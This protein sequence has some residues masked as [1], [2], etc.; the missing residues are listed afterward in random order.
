[1]PAI[2]KFIQHTFNK[3]DSKPQ[4]LIKKKNPPVMPFSRSNTSLFHIKAKKGITQ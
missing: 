1:M 2:Y 4:V 3:T